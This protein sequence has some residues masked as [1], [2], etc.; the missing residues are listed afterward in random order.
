MLAVEYIE[1]VL[2][3]GKEYFGLEVIRTKFPVFRFEGFVKPFS[4]YFVLDSRSSDPGLSRVRG[5]VCVVFLG[6]TLY[7]HSL[8]QTKCINDAHK[9]SHH[10]SLLIYLVR[11]IDSVSPILENKNF[12]P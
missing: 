5:T 2:G 9:S 6:K 4:L 3:N 8:S 1:A 12:V 11:F 10:S 7:S